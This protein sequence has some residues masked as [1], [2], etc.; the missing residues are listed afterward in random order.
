LNVADTGDRARDFLE[1]YDWTWPQ[2]VD[3]NRRKAKRFGVNWQPAVI[4]I[5]AKG[6][7]AGV[8]QSYDRERAWN[9]LAAKLP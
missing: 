9:R 5:D 1:R 3:T 8:D 6:R 7:I 2:L 4:A